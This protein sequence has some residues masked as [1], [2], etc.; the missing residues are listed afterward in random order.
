MERLL[1]REA[2]HALCLAVQLEII[3]QELDADVARNL[4]TA[5]ITVPRYADAY[6]RRD[7][8]RIVNGSSS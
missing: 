1:P 2:L 8:V 4:D 7:G 6:V 5:A 3:S